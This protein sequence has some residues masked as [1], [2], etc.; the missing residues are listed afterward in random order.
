MTIEELA[1]YVVNEIVWINFCNGITIVILLITIIVLV[2]KLSEM[3][4]LI[5][6]METEIRRMKKLLKN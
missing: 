2:V 1:S 3:N 6:N 4:R 5:G